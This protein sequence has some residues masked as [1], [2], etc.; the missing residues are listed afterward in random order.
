MFII[1]HLFFF[2]FVRRKKKKKK[3][4]KGPADDMLSK[5]ASRVVEWPARFVVP[6]R[7]KTGEK[8]I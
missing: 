3:K 1:Q 4:K 5:Q 8:R 7:E 2:F 6:E